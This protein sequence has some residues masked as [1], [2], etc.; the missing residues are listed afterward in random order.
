MPS[1]FYVAYPVSGN[2]N[3]DINTAVAACEASA[4]RAE[5]AATRAENAPAFV[6][7][8]IDDA[9]A[10]KE[11]AEAAA[12]TAQ[13]AA[14]A[15]QNAKAAAE[16]AQAA[17][18]AAV[19][20]ASTAAQDADDSETAARTAAT[21]SAA[22]AAA[23]AAK[24]LEAA[25]SASTF[26]GIAKS[27][28][29]VAINDLSGAASGDYSLVASDKFAAIWR[30]QSAITGVVVPLNWHTDAAADGRPSFAWT[31]VYNAHA[32]ASMDIKIPAATDTD[33]IIT[34]LVSGTYK[35]AL[36]D[37]SAEVAKTVT[38]DFTAPAGTNRKCSLQFA[39]DLANRTS[40]T[41]NTRT[42]AISGITG[43]ATN[44]TKALSDTGPGGHK[45][46][47]PRQSHV[48]WTFDLPDSASA[49]TTHTISFSFPDD[50]W[51]AAWRLTVAK[52]VLSVAITGAS[53][54][55]ATLSPSTT[56]TAI[57][58]G[59]SVVHFGMVGGDGGPE[60]AR[61]VPSGSY[62][63]GIT[64][65][66]TATGGADVSSWYAYHAPTTATSETFSVTWTTG[67]ARE[68][69]YSVALFTPVAGTSPVTIWNDGDGTV[70]LAA[71]KIADIEALSIGNLYVVRIIN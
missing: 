19:S 6:D 24:A 58:H 56:F 7:G 13:T 54:T 50:V 32:S 35:T 59:A 16:T 71:G 33:V 15:S 60:G 17:A 53:I 5:A 3:D 18:E 40:P 65:T 57:A 45:D 55:T 38:W 20:S 22:S 36:A 41:T 42:F 44:I 34:A 62:V 48:G 2:V 11:D 61:T 23:A 68:G 27:L 66:G 12:T 1:S 52:Q 4:V 31:R 8:T 46:L 10:A 37:A 28:A 29:G 39:A 69:S 63:D 67:A 51:S 21:D 9:V 25:N 14:T 64:S 47:S 70:A 30:T 49:S 43:G 26:P